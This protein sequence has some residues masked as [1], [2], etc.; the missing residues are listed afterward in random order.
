MLLNLL[1]LGAHTRPTGLRRDLTSSV[2]MA[3]SFRT[4]P[5]YHNGV[6]LSVRDSEE[7]TKTSPE[8]ALSYSLRDLEG[9]CSPPRLLRYKWQVCSSSLLPKRSCSH[10]LLLFFIHYPSTPQSSCSWNAADISPSYGV[11]TLLCLCQAFSSGLLSFTF[12]L[13][14]HAWTR[15]RTSFALRQ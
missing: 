12:T 5:V 11:H 6:S 9:K 7:E 14:L 10:H 15:H 13:N 1:A 3:G 2:E 4:G 8:I